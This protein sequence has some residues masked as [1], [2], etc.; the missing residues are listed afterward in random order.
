MRIVPGGSHTRSTINDAPERMSVALLV[1][2]TA[3]ATPNT[4]PDRTAIREMGL[5]RRAAHRASELYFCQHFH[6]IRG[7]T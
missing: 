7:S 5:F 2:R 6:G 1:C 4:S 3:I